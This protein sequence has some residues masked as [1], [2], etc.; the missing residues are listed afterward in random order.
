MNISTTFQTLESEITQLRG[1]LGSRL[2]LKAS[3]CVLPAVADGEEDM[4]IEHIMPELK[5]G[6]D[7]VHAACAA[8]AD[9]H[10]R[11]GYSQKSARRTTGVLW[12]DNTDAEFSQ[13]VTRLVTSI[14]QHK[15]S[16]QRHIIENYGGDRRPEYMR[17][18]ALHSACPGVMTLHLYRQLRMFDNANV[19]LVSFGW[20]QKTLFSR[21]NKIE[22]LQKMGKDIE[23]DED[24]SVRLNSLIKAIARVP[25]EKLRLRRPV[26]VHPAANIA[27]ADPEHPDQ[28]LR[29]SAASSMPFIIIQDEHVKIRPLPEFVANEVKPRS[30]RLKTDVIVIFHGES[31]EMI[32]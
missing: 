21:V 8:Y 14:N 28:I 10:I 7:A 11:D 27:M 19:N 12:Y 22:L 23:E 18:N 13:L 4:A 9:L 16:I 26:K 3:V 17:F 30:N 32:L 6:H 15:E 2:P 20:R 24:K 1:V 29:L 31:I 25:E 5:Q